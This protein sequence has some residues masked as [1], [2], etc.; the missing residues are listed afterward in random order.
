MS[1]H[2]SG[3]R[4]AAETHLQDAVVRPFGIHDGGVGGEGPELQRQPHQ[5][6]VLILH[7]VVLHVAAAAEGQRVAVW[8]GA[9]DVFRVREEE[10]SNCTENKKM[11]QEAEAGDGMDVLKEMKAKNPSCKG[12]TDHVV[13]VHSPF[14]LW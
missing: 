9:K 1:F 10:K 5:L 2:R 12:N 13:W 6:L 14:L 4:D 8:Q 3:W 11:N 7:Q